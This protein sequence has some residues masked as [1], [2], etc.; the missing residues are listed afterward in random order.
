MI[1]ASKSAKRPLYAITPSQKSSS[2]ASF[3]IVPKQVADCGIPPSLEVSAC[4]E[5][6]NALVHDPF[7]NAQ[8]AIDPSFDIFA[9][10]NL[11]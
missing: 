5:N 8:I 4:A 1:H 7:S 9:V 10:G 2:S 3:I 11:V 6:H